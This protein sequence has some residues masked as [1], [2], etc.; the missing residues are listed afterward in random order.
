[1]VLIGNEMSSKGLGFWVQVDG[2]K[3]VGVTRLHKEF[4]KEISIEFAA[5]YGVIEKFGKIFFCIIQI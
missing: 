5:I 4:C 2:F 3:V 1:M